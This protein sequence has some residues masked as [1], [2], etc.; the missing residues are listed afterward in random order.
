MYPLDARSPPTP[1]APPVY[2]QDVMNND[3]VA[4]FCRAQ[5]Q[6]TASKLAEALVREAVRNRGSGDNTTVIAVRLQY[7]PPP[8]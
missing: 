7:A 8:P 3:E 1:R 6:L 5:H 2:P 4:M